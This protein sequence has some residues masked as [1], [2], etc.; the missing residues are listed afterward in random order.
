MF[1]AKIQPS[2]VHKTCFINIIHIFCLLL[3]LFIKKRKNYKILVKMGKIF[4]KSLK[5]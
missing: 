3:Q 5:S 4:T 1:T 2:S